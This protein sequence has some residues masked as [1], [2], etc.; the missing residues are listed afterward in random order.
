M[1]NRYQEAV[2][3]VAMPI[4]QTLLSLPT[5][6]QELVEE[7]RLRASLPVVLVC[8]DGMFLVDERG[9]LVT[10]E[11]QI[12]LV[13]SYECLQ[14]TF[15]AVCGYSVHTHQREMVKGYITLKGGHRVGIA[16]TMVE[17]DGVVT[18]VKE[19]SSLSIRVAKEWKQIANELPPEALEE[20]LL[21][22]G[23][24]GCGKT[25]LLRD[26]ARSISGTGN[27]LGKKVAVLDERGELAAMWDG[28]PQ[29]DMGLNTDVLNGFSKITGM[30]IAVRSLSPQVIVCDEIGSGE[31]AKS[32]M[33]CVYAGVEIIASV[34][35]K[36]AEELYEKPWVM[37]LIRSNVFPHIAFF[38]VEQNKR[39]ISVVKTK[40]WLHEMD[41]SYHGVAYPVSC[42]GKGT[43]TI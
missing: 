5:S 34:H 35:G 26:I 2:G 9:N 19:I 25:T 33:N 21:L 13:C 28:I 3:V 29:N 39:K 42:G 1:Q 38:S 14:Q 31:E 10:Y 11:S 16:A 41:R 12:P 6:R 7:I 23:P 17:R 20:G 24:P 27:I 43:G 15:R 30:E 18:S 37:E 36:S 32:L 22:V 4:R 40:D 8:A